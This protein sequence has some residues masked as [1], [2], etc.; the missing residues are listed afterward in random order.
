[1][2]RHRTTSTRR[3]AHLISGAGAGLLAGVAAVAVSEAVAA[4]L[5]GVSSPLLSVANRA[6]DAAPRPLKEFAIETF[7]TADKPVLIGSVIATVAGLAVVAGVL[8]VRRP[9]LA[10]GLFL[11]LSVVAT[12]AALTDRSATAGAVAR[13]VPA[14]AL[15]AVGTVALLALLRPLRRSRRRLLG[16]PRS[17]P[18]G[19][20]R[21]QAGPAAPDP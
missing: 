13:L 6:V 1:M 21:D 15:M 3:T 5:D 11:A 20:P 9:R 14:V 19:R 8:G 2:T 4:L 12:V 7:G 18:G 10:V 16:R 17:H